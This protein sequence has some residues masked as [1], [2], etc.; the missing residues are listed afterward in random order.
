MCPS[1]LIVG[2]AFVCSVKLNTYCSYGEIRPKN[3][4]SMTAQNTD[5]MLLI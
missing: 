3:V 4:C 1:V 2:V 5:I